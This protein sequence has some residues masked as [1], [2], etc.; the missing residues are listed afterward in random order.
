MALVV[1]A[2]DGED[3]GPVGLV[4]ANAPGFDVLAGFCFEFCVPLCT[5]GRHGFFLWDSRETMDVL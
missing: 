4:W 5:A 2:A 1:P 3:V